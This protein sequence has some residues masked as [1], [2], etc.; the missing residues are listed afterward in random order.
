MIM[1]CPLQ[2][3]QAEHGDWK[4]HWVREKKKKTNSAKLPAVKWHVCSE[5][6][7]LMELMGFLH[8]EAFWNTRTILHSGKPEQS[9]N[10]QCSGIEPM[11]YS[12]HSHSTNHCTTAIMHFGKAACLFIGSIHIGY[13][14][15]KFMNLIFCC[16]SCVLLMLIWTLDN[17]TVV[18]QSLFIWMNHVEQTKE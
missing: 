13:A 1:H 11:I 3:Q 4:I 7:C 15:T 5:D 17:F 9:R 12:L 6:K 16:S 2:C 8:C 10:M 18:Q 14:N